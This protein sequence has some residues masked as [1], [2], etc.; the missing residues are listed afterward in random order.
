MAERAH[1]PE[2][3]SFVETVSPCGQE[4]LGCGVVA[5]DGSE[6]V[7]LEDDPETDIPTAFLIAAGPDLLE[8]LVKAE[9]FI[10][11]EYEDQD[12]WAVEGEPLARCARET[13]R[14][15]CAAIARATGE[16]EAKE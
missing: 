5:S 6:F 15:I 11:S 7:W 2:P 3:W 10:A 8:A 16:K 4:W 1:R 13:H 14:A 9:A 12:C